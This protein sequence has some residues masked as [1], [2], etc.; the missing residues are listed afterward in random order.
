MLTNLVSFIYVFFFLNLYLSRGL[1]LICISGITHHFLTV[2]SSPLLA[3]WP[4]TF[5]PSE[6]EMPQFNPPC[7]HPFLH[8][9]E[10]ESSERED[11]EIVR[12]EENKI[13]W[14]IH[15]FFIHFHLGRE[16]PL[17]AINRSSCCHTVSTWRLLEG[18]LDY[19]A[20]EPRQKTNPPPHTYTHHFHLPSITTY[21]N[22]FTNTFTVQSL[23]KKICLFY[24]RKYQMVSWKWSI[25]QH[26][27]NCH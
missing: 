27:I 17:T 2:I 4:L 8:D 6:R 1:T 10:G 23:G 12:K 26:L 14:K 15:Q 24:S 22:H 20:L 5:K 25:T 3:P 16:N 21:C 19:R 7:Y 11:R 9:R 18:L 13:V